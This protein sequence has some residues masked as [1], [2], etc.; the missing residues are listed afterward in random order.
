[1]NVAHNGSSTGLKDITEKEIMVGDKIQ[2]LGGYEGVVMFGKYSGQHYG[3][4]IK[5]E[6]A[7]TDIH[8]LRKDILFW[9]NQVRVE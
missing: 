7:K 9:L 3:V 1:M 4:Y 6:K 8:A 5:W 2:T